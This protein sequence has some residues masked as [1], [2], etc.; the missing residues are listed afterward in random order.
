MDFITFYESEVTFVIM[1][2]IYDS[3]IHC[4]LCI[5]I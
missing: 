5:R 2:R 3:K 1:F 4:S